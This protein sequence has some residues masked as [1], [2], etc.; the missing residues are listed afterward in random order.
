[1]DDNRDIADTTSEILQGAGYEPLAVYSGAEALESMPSFAPQLVISDVTM[2]QMS[3]IDL[4]YE[5]RHT[6]PA[7]AVIL[8]SGDTAAEELQAEAVAGSVTVLGKPIPPRQLL[9]IIAELTR[10][11]E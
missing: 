8:L 5:L 9:K 10:K 4:M 1:V 7:V 3:G 11:A 2:P 6:H